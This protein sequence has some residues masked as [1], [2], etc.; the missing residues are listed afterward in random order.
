MNIVHTGWHEDSSNGEETADDHQHAKWPPTTPAVH[1][2][3]AEQV[4]GNLN[5]PG[6]EE[7]EVFIAAHDRAIVR[8]AD[9]DSVV[10]KP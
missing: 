4:P 1:H 5:E 9:V 7:R 6:Q 3:P 2:C 10:S 8:Q